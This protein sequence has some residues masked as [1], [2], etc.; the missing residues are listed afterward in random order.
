MTYLK[1]NKINKIDKSTYKVCFMGA[2]MDTGNRGVSALAA[3]VL[4]IIRTFKPE[5]EIS[6][7]IGNRFSRPQDVQLLKSTVQVKVVNYRLSPKARLH[8]HLFWIFLIACLQRFVSIKSV[9]E[10][11]IKTN[12]FLHAMHQ[13]DFVGDISGGDSFSDIYGIKRL[14]VR[15]MPKVIAL[16]LNKKLVL[17]PQ[18]Y[19][20]FSSK[21]A[22]YIAQY[23]LSRAAL[24]LSRDKESIKVIQRLTGD[25][26]LKPKVIFCP[27]VAFVLDSIIPDSVNI[28]PPVDTNKSAPIIGLN[29]N[30][31]M[32]NGGYTRDNM[33][34]LKFD[35]NKFVHQ[36]VI[37]LLEATESH[38]ILV[39]HTFGLPGSINS[40]PDACRNVLNTLPDLYKDR[41]HMVIG[42]YDQSEIKGIINS[43]DFFIGSRMH[44]CIAALSQG[45]PTI[46]IAYSKKFLGVFNSIGTGNTVADAR[47]SDEI[48]VINKVLQCFEKRNEISVGAMVN[49][50][51]AQAR[52]NAVFKELISE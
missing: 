42:E 16:L 50:S 52:I 22:K 8:K 7:F 21:F 13:S 12:P 32:Y 26:E 27:D 31:L 17:L 44:A 34:G 33:F 11:I 2:S 37:R 23:I 24:I 15:S 45:I 5:A 29:L 40:D 9:R 18:T 1:A 25:R 14:I 47:E 35:Y 41:V 39:P 46:G 49:V 10:K 3:S 36:L 38:I 4:K 51:S 28:Q 30:G 48:T 6:F 20:P 19:G 43:C